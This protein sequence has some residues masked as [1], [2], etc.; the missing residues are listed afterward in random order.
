VKS[1]P[2]ILR[3]V[4]AIVRVILVKAQYEIFAIPDVYCKLT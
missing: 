4:V 2:I 1:F 3:I